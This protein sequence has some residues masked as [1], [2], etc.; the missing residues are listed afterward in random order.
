MG[1]IGPNGCLLFHFHALSKR[2]KSIK[3]PLYGRLVL[4]TQGHVKR[5]LGH[6][7]RPHVS[8]RRCRLRR[9]RATS[10]RASA[11]APKPRTLSR[12]IWCLPNYPRPFPGLDRLCGKSICSPA[13]RLKTLRRYKNKRIRRP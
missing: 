4:Q 13:G 3:G 9:M 7:A 2:I 12:L 11:L 8:L 6:Q 10:I 5:R 1:H